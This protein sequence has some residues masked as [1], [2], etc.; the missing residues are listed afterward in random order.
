MSY[1]TLNAKIAEL[2]RAVSDVAVVYEYD[3]KELAN[4]PSVTVS[5]ISHQNQMYDTAANKRN[6]TFI[7]RIYNRNDDTG[8]SEATLLKLLD[9]ITD[10]LESKPTLEG[11]CDIARATQAKWAYQDREVPVR[12]IELT[13]EASKRV[14]R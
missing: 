7:V 6:F 12:V 13:I 4:F 8:A 3:K 5:P 9:D 11:A 2:I 14:L 10:A 1:V